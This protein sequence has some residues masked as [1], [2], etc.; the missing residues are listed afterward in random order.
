MS[1][2]LLVGPARYDSTVLLLLPQ[3][4][5]HDATTGAYGLSGQPRV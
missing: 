3:N 2:D 4:T 1:P 5:P